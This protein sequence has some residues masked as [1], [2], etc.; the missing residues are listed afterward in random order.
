ML[1]KEDPPMLEDK[2]EDTLVGMMSMS[3][4]FGWLHDHLDRRAAEAAN[5]RKASASVQVDDATLKAWTAEEKRREMLE[6]FTEQENLRYSDVARPEKDA[7]DITKE[8]IFDVIEPLGYLPEMNAFHSGW[9]GQLAQDDTMGKLQ[10][11]AAV[12]VMPLAEQEK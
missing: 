4:K 1:A 2:A 12:L 5:E 8:K 6:Y 10:R 9:F 7:R 11:R 3:D